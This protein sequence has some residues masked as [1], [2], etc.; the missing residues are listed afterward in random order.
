MITYEES[1]KA[2]PPSCLDAAYERK[3]ILN[4]S[5]INKATFP[6]NEKYMIKDSKMDEY[7]DAGGWHLPKG[8]V[9]FDYGK[10]DYSLLPPEAIDGV[11]RVLTMGATKYGRRN[12]ERGLSYSRLFAACMRHLWAWWR[13]EELDPESGL[14][15]LHHAACNIV[16]L[17][18]YHERGKT[19]WDD[20]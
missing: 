2:D 14:S 6:E 5:V 11:V 9:K 20:R 17:Q 4:G 13:G 15:H 18:T 8:G 3:A 12:W 10:P 19:E 7:G 1:E 16:M